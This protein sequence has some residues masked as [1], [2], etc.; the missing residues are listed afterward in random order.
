MSNICAV[1]A[2]ISKPLFH[3]TTLH[4]YWHISRHPLYSHCVKELALPTTITV[5]EATLDPVVSQFNSVVYPDKQNEDT[6]HSTTY[7]KN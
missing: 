1:Y 6:P 4:P 2:R 7:G 3:V 5:Q